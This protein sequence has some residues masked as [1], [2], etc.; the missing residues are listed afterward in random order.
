M[1]HMR[2]GWRVDNGIDVFR[3]ISGDPTLQRFSVVEVVADVQTYEVR[4]SLLNQDGQQCWRKFYCSNISKI[5]EIILNKDSIAAE[6]CVIDVG[7]SKSIVLGEPV[8]EIFEVAENQETR[9]FFCRTESGVLLSDEFDK[10]SAEVCD[11]A[12]LI[13]HD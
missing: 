6:I 12:K 1:F 13:W 8:L 11:R 7:R 5:I 9:L 3:A 10:I 4:V 2:D